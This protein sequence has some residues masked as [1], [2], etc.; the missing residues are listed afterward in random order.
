LLERMSVTREHLRAEVR[1]LLLTL[2]SRVSLPTALRVV[3]L[4]LELERLLEE[5]R[6]EVVRGKDNG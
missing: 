4:V 1:D 5:E 6:A 3:G 2:K